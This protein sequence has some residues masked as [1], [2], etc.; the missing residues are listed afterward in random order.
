MAKFETLH[1]SGSEA[2]E[3]PSEDVTDD[4]DF[5]T[6]GDEDELEIL[7]QLI[8]ANGFPT[9]AGLTLLAVALIAVA[10]EVG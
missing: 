5:D 4:E 3:Y 2:W 9:V 8:L 6:A 7:F 1:R 10:W